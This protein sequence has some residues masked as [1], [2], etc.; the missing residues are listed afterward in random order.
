MEDEIEDCIRKKIQ[1][2]QLPATVKKLLGDSPKEYERYIFEFSIKNQL[3]FRGSLVRTVRKD[4]KKYYET[5]VQCSIQRL[6]LYPYHLA[7][8]IV[9][10][11]Y[12]ILYYFD[13]IILYGL[14][15][16]DKFVCFILNLNGFS[17]DF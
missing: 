1:W 13:Y 7:D 6:M 4:E 2:P 8:M 16:V 12:I 17:V 9:K 10:G 5:L 15:K 14:C 11:V 3:R